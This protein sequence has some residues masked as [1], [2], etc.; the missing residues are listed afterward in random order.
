[1]TI[2]LAHG[3]HWVGQLLYVAPVL[4]VAA[5]L[6]VSA[7]RERRRGDERHEATGEPR[8]E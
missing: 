8:P 2:V 7:L 1:M 5:V 6:K 3:G 4:V